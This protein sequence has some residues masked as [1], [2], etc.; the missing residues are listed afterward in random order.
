MDYTRRPNLTKAQRRRQGSEPN[1]RI[2]ARTPRRPHY[3]RRG[4]ITRDEITHAVALR[5]KP[6][7]HGARGHEPSN[8]EQEHTFPPHYNDSDFRTALDFRRRFWNWVTMHGLDDRSA[9]NLLIYLVKGKALLYLTTTNREFSSWK[10][11][12]QLLIEHARLWDL[13]ADTERRDN[14]YAIDRSDILT[15][16]E[17]RE[18]PW[19]TGRR[20]PRPD[21]AEIDSYFP[22]NYYGNSRAEALRFKSKFAEWWT[23]KK[24]T[25][26]ECLNLLCYLVRGPMQCLL[27]NTTYCF[28]SWGEIID[29]TIGYTPPDDGQEVELQPASPSASRS[30]TPQEVGSPRSETPLSPNR[31]E[32][33]DISRRLRRLEGLER[34]LTHPTDVTKGSVDTQLSTIRQRV[35]EL[36]CGVSD[37]L[38]EAR[39]LHQL[40]DEIHCDVTSHDVELI[41]LQQRSAAHA[42]ELNS[43]KV[44]TGRQAKRASKQPSSP[45]VALPQAGE[46][47][48]Q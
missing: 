26:E 20:G 40:V 5:R 31:S 35:A 28:Q 24:L 7:V 8:R 36:S 33:E 3:Q 29:W 4:L 1:F 22:G 47:M 14:P 2:T 18:L 11:V 17:K 12:L 42:L 38:D 6:W 44:N 23:K 46:P 37:A 48:P 27:A 10:G 15:A 34:Y 19:E 43:M 9:L 30:S 39:G 25:E 45:S 21:Q 13:S 16:Q 32:V 41:K